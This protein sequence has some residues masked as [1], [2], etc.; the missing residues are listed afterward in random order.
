M[1][2]RSRTAE[3]SSPQSRRRASAVAAALIVTT[4]LV[5]ACAA[6]PSPT[7]PD[8]TAAP[9]RSTAT[10][11]PTLS[12]AQQLLVD[13]G[14][15]DGCVVVFAGDAIADAPEVETAGQRYLN[16]PIP[17][18]DGRVFT[19]WYT[20]PGAAAA[21]EIPART[22]GA[23]VVACDTPDREIDLYAG[24]M[25]PEELA[26]DT[27]RVPILMFH[28]FTDKPG[29]EDNWLR[30]NYFD[31]GQWREDLQYIRDAG[32]YLPTWDEMD[33]FI[34]GKV[35]FPRE[36]VVITDDDADATW[37]SMAVPIA[38]ELQ[39]L[40]TS[41]VITEARQDPTP[42]PW[43]LQRSHTHAM[44]TAGADGNGRIVNATEGEIIADMRTSA[45]ILG[46]AEVM[47]YPFGHY[48][49]T[50]KAALAAA[51]FTLAVTTEHGYVTVGSDKLALPRIRMNWGMTLDDLRRAID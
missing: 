38:D 3:D 46:V 11:T 4:M 28:Q 14:N 21:R 16:L 2:G 41:F 8:S 33:A 7:T 17:A 35:W 18:A 13:S 34:D 32:F 48:N 12:P 26:A 19:G 47:A 25:T 40:T 44:H 15:P 29:G 51:G 39:V 1:V 31:V 5:A 23:D 10:P 42:S 6:E 45:D 9:E 22:N 20:S 27:A 43:V 50:A 30:L 24:W 36:T 37:L 49:D